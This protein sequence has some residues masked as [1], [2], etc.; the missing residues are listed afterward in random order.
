MANEENS[1][2]RDWR[3]SMKRVLG[4]DANP[5]GYRADREPDASWHRPS[6]HKRGI[7]TLSKEQ[8]ERDKE[9]QQRNEVRRR[10]RERMEKLCRGFLFLFDED[11]KKEKCKEDEFEYIPILPPNFPLK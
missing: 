4:A 8:I 10:H 11:F 2:A 1:G 6:N 9:L 5:V 7:E 3:E